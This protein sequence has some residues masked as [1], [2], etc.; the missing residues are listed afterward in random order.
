[1]HME[2]NNQTLIICHACDA[3]QDVS[4]IP[5]GNIASCICCGIRLF[6]NTK[7]TVERPLALLIACSIFFII[8]NIYPVL[9]LNIAGIERETTLIETAFMFYTEGSPVLAVVVVLT[10]FIFPGFCVFSLLYV[11]MAIYFKKNWYFTRSLLVWSSQLLPWAMLDVY[12]LAILV[13]VVKLVSLASVILGIG[14]SAMVGFVIFYAACISSIE[15][16][17]L[18][19]KLDENCCGTQYE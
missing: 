15:M 9:Q 7:H 11:F 16:H 2:E 10:S 17:V 4:H 1:M 3:L 8:A 5:K 14:F 18:W 19:T 13:A 12:L 6:K